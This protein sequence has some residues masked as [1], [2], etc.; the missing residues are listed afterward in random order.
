[1]RNCLGLAVVL[2]ACMHTNTIAVD[3]ATLGRVV[4][5]RNGVAFY[6]KR[7]TVEDGKLSVHVPRE[8]IDDFLKSLTVIDP[9]TN[10]PLSVTIPRAEGPD[11]YLKLTLDSGDARRAD[12]LL[13]YVTEAAAWKPS[14]RVV[15][16]RPGKVMLEAW[17][18]VD[19]VSGED[20]NRVQVG[21]GASSALSFRYDLWGV[22]R[23]DRDLLQGEDHFVVAPP[24]GVSP[25]PAEEEIVAIDGSAA[26]PSNTNLTDEE[27]AKL[28]ELEG[29][30]EVI[31]V[32]GSA[33]E[34]KQPTTSMATRTVTVDALEAVPGVVAGE[35]ADAPAVRRPDDGHLSGF[36]IDSRS[37][38]HMPGVSVSATDG[39]TTQTTR[40]DARG[41]YA[42]DLPP[43]R[44]TVSFFYGDAHV[45]QVVDVAAGQK[46][47]TSAKL[48]Q[49]RQRGE[50]AR[51]APPP[52]APP[53]PAANEA[54]QLRAAA[55]R[56]IDSK[57]DV[58]IE[59]HGTDATAV[60]A[61]AG[62]LR[63]Q[64][65]ADGVASARVRVVS[66]VGAG[67][68]DRL[69]ILAVAPGAAPAARPGMPDTPVGESRFMA[70]RPMTVP[71]GSSAMVAMV[72]GETT[73]GVVYLYDPISERGDQRFAFKSVRFDN[74]TGNALESGPVTV[75][76]DGRFIGEG[77]TEAVPPHASVVVP[78]ALDRQIV[79]TRDG[80]DDDRVAKLITAER[81]V[82]TAELQHR[83]TTTFSITSRLGEPTVVYLR[84]R[85]ESGWTLVD[86]PSAVSAMTVGDS[87]L[88]AV[89]VP[90]G[91][92]RSV[93]LV[94]A[95]PVERTLQLASA[96]A[97]ALM[98]LYVDSPDASPRFKAQL[99]AV[100]ATHREV[101]DFVDHIAALR[102]Q[103]G[104]YRERAGEL[105]AQLV[106]LQA[107]HTGGEL[108]A[109]LRQRL[110]EITD[111]TQ[112]T[113]LA[114]VDSQER[115]MLERVQLQNQLA[116]LHL[117]DATAM[118]R[119]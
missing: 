3:G 105:H 59:A 13:T 60:A 68:P 14:Y 117:D 67:E 4:I 48:D 20:W 85:L 53:P 92:T 83:R 66:K 99:Q 40:T 86:A 37:G 30:E 109:T 25:Y 19:N 38:D 39:N 119:R 24:T 34:R 80:H 71:A 1:M 12:V 29:K 73:G 102:E 118:T 26:P 64:L 104:D 10:R 116:D 22:R 45:T 55:K 61:R 7:A 42:F 33:V 74:P 46:S 18:I 70:E 50:T 75:F 100:L 65:V 72:H 11:G 111:R 107:V 79:V 95:T 56:V 21:V 17:A 84:H 2:S 41:A 82:V 27:I 90:A 63:D 110:I 57:R 6:E 9:S 54:D 32:T 23:V 89:D 98:Q 103:L 101:A 52:P 87:Q 114:L 69:R 112:K 49:G 36:A 113:T 5:Y 8:R 62:A 51:A 43:G 28:A 78:F 93:A 94:E 106:T 108:M 91:A 96:D 115:L 15:V 76:G 97:L 16:G 31:V 81:G 58:V 35:P 47:A 77:I 88:F 44:Y